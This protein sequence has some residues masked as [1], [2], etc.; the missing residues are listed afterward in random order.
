MLLRVS[1]LACALA[2]ISSL[3][4]EPPGRSQEASYPE[5]PE[6]DC[7]PFLHLRRGALIE[8]IAFSAAYLQ[9]APHQ[10]CI[11]LPS[12][13]GT[14]P[15]GVAVYTKGGR[16]FL[17]SVTY[18]VVPLPG[19]AAADINR[20][21]KILPAM[22]AAVRQ[23]G[24]QASS[25]AAESDDT[26]L[27]K[28]ALAVSFFPSALS[29]VRL[30][31]AGSAGRSTRV[32]VLDWDQRHYLWNP[33][34]GVIEVPV[35]VDPLTRTPYLCV[36]QP[37]LPGSIL[38]AAEYGRLH[39]NE[40]AQVLLDPR[41]TSHPLSWFARGAAVAAYTDGGRVGLHTG[42]E[43][44][45][46]PEATP[47]DFAHLGILTAKAFACYHRFLEERGGRAGAVPDGL[48]GDT[49]DLQLRRAHFRLQV[50]NA[51]PGRIR[52]NYGVLVIDCGDLQ[53]AYAPG[54]GAAYSGWLPPYQALLIDGITFA[55]AYRRDHPGE[56]AV[57]VAHP[58]AGRLTYPQGGI[59]AHVFYTRTGE[60]WG[61]LAEDHAGEYRV[62]GAPASAIDDRRRLIGLCAP[63][64]PAQ[65][66]LARAAVDLLGDKYRR[67]AAGLSDYD[68]RPY[69]AG[70]VLALLRRE[71]VPC[72]LAPERERSED[73]RVI[74]Y[75]AEAVVFR[76]AGEAFV[77]ARQ[78][79]F[80]ARARGY[81]PDLA[82]E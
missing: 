81:A 5:D 26:Q 40:R 51:R 23:A 17:R 44:I 12:P 28:A 13:P 67:P 29:E 14:Q 54:H 75:P 45:P 63:N 47:A 9:A 25:P 8:S 80:R 76:W 68:G 60:L 65:E 49:S 58:P 39:P 36:P 7:L 78:R 46:L 22:A 32:L 55:G 41:M 30:A 64:Q 50:A 37:E 77:Y 31:R 74:E 61:H 24:R 56:S 10:D 42:S 3:R 52:N 57:V 62:G 59:N 53:C 71:G 15:G 18:G 33:A 2:L 1:L 79:V 38:F 21:D 48:I 19:L 20:L 16:L 35:P 66:A 4:A 34:A 69:G 72:R 70:A 27:A 73:G 11:V 6:A 82:L 43:N